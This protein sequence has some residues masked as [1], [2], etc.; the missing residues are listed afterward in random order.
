MKEL[1]SKKKQKTKWQNLLKELNSKAK[2]YPQVNKSQKVRI[3]SVNK[4]YRKVSNMFHLP[5]MRISSSL[6]PK[7]T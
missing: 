3:Y 7:S 4:E 2:N 5:L 6:S 1:K